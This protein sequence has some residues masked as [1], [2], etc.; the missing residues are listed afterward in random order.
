MVRFCSL[1][2]KLYCQIAV[3]QRISL[4]FIQ[5]RIDTDSTLLSKLCFTALLVVYTPIYHFT[6]HMHSRHSSPASSR[7]VYSGI[8]P[9]TTCVFILLYVCALTLLCICADPMRGYTVRTDDTHRR[10]QGFIWFT[11][12]T[13]WTHFFKWDSKSPDAGLRGTGGIVQYTTGSRS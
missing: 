4:A 10:L 6:I 11:T 12:F 5:D 2:T 1:T 13:S 3:Q 7:L 8:P 9:T